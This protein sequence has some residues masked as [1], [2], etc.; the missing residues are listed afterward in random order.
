M[1]VLGNSYTVYWILLDSYQNRLESWNFVEVLSVAV[2]LLTGIYIKGRTSG[3]A[4][5]AGI[6]INLGTRRTSSRHK[7]AKV[8]PISLRQT[9]KRVQES[10]F[11]LL[12]GTFIPCTYWYSDNR[13]ETSHS[14][15]MQSSCPHPYFMHSSGFRIISDP[16]SPFQVWKKTQNILTSLNYLLRNVPRLLYL[17]RHP[18]SLTLPGPSITDPRSS[19]TLSTTRNASVTQHIPHSSHSEFSH[20]KLQEVRSRLAIPVPPP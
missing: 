5:F 17:Y 7:I 2:L 14:Y 8:W 4:L 3:T 12:Y 13:F 16:A 15:S 10:P 11:L 9:F 18:C 19:Y 20:P 1:W 6:V